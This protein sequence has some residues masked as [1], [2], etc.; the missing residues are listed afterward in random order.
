MCFLG[1]A[2]GH[3]FQ[4]H[5]AQWIE[6]AAQWREGLL[7]PRWAL[8]SNSGFGEPRFIFYPPLSWMLGAALGSVLPWKIV[9]GVLVW[10]ALTISG[11]SMWRFAGR[12]LSQTQ[13]IA[14]AIFFA[15]NPYHIAVIYY[16]SA[17]AELLA[18]AI[19]PLLLL[20]A[21]GVL[22]R[23]WRYGPL[24]AFAFAAV[25]LSN[26]PAGV[27]ATY[28]LLV[29][30]AAVLTLRRNLLPA[31]SIAVA[32]A[33]GLGVAAFYLVP[34]WWEQRWVQISQVV[35][36]NLDP[37]KNFLF[38]RL[39]E[40]EFVQFNWKISTVAVILIAFSATGLVLCFKRRREWPEVWWAICA[41]IF[42]SVML[43]L[44]I[45]A[46]LWRLVPKLRFIQFPWRW[47]FPLGFAFAFLGA[48]VNFKR[49]MAWGVIITAAICVTAATICGDTTWSSDDVG[50]VLEDIRAGRGY[51]GIDGFEPAGAKVDELDDEQ[52]LVAEY[53]SS[54][55]ETG[56]P[57][58]AQ[59]TMTSWLAEARV[60]EVK[61]EQPITI[62]VKLL[63]YPAWQ[64]RVDGRKTAAETAKAAGQILIS[65]SPGSHHIE[66]N[67][68][69]TRDRTV[70]AL[71]SFGSIVVLIAAA[72]AF[73]A[74][75]PWAGS[76]S[77]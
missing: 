74:K 15:A 14:A 3:D 29:I 7:V 55:G 38:T 48:A 44:P 4:P 51:E 42:V 73:R 63:N 57:E 71:I 33:A 43:L 72:L 46:W 52:P 11:C 25:W 56:E 54:S 47:L 12:C 39:N 68:G 35:S 18:S 19:F 53:D 32:M 59:V 61:S 45:S 49:N 16:R 6:A 34:A 36:T 8:W 41:L 13:A 67:F 69:R 60:F 5:V 17:F 77:T 2:S 40:P 76:G 26:A 31:I 64:I 1:N 50:T 24:L 65:L 22:R 62:A 27:I 10:L 21:F 20:G 23:E 30:V 37:E 75:H 28:S 70:G 66:I 9:P 58:D